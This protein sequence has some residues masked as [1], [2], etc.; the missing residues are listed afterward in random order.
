MA[1]PTKFGAVRS[2]TNG[3]FTAQ[4]VS[5]AIMGVAGSA[6]GPITASMALYDALAT[7]D[8]RPDLKERAYGPGSGLVSSK[9]SISS[10]V[11]NYNSA[12]AGTYI[13][14]RITS[15]IAGVASTALL[16]MGCANKIKAIHEKNHDSGVKM[17]T[18][19]VGN[20]FSWTGKLA[21]GNS[22][23]SRL[24][25]LNAAS[26]AVVTPA[27]LN[28]VFLWDIADGNATNKAVD[29]AATPSR[30]IPGEFI[31]LVDFVTTPVLSGGNAFDYKPIT[32]M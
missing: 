31:L 15:T 11:Y 25:W 8:I 24:M 29:N 7:N 3:D 1:V 6:T 20:S 18:S 5:G 4:N 32:G 13:I 19:W 17:L 10:G 2:K 16:F 26:T 12:A 9:K 22:K 23:L 28:G 30:S 21:N 27:P 14:S